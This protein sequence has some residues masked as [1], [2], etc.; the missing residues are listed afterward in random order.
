MI[1]AAGGGEYLGDC[2]DVAVVT[3]HGLDKILVVVVER[4]HGCQANS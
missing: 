4:H 2:M 3:K 1:A